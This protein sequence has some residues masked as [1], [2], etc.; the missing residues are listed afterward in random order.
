MMTSLWAVS[1]A[2]AL[3]WWE[4]YVVRLHVHCTVYTQQSRSCDCDLTGSGKRL[5]VDYHYDD[6]HHHYYRD[7]QE[8]SWSGGGLAV[9]RSDEETMRKMEERID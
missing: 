8:M 9:E 1:A 3:P 5:M 6:D 2:V 7:I 4:M